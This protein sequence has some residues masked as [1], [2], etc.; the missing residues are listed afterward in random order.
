MKKK[1]G[2]RMTYSVA[3]LQYVLLYV[4][5]IK[6]AVVCGMRALFDINPPND[7]KSNLVPTILKM[8]TLARRHSP[9]CY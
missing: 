7:Y 2:V 9:I 1:A 6:S 3:V 5:T 8:Y 4:D